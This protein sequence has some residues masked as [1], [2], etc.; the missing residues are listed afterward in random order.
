M[1]FSLS[2]S[3]LNPMGDNWK[4]FW[5]GEGEGGGGIRGTFFDSFESNLGTWFSFLQ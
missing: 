2:S 5:G 1:V 4:F 3:L